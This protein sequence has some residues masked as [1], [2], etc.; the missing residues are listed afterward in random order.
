MKGNGV[1]YVTKKGKFCVDVKSAGLDESWCRHVFSVGDN[2]YYVTK[3]LRPK[4]YAY[5]FSLEKA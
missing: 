2:Y 5:R 4:S 1:W 3:D